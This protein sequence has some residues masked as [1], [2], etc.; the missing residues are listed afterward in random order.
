MMGPGG[1]GGPM[2]GGPQ[3]MGGQQLH[4]K[5]FHSLNFYY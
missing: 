1:P 3:M 4:L 2:M 5:I